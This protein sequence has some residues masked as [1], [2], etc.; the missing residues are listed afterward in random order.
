MD[1]AFVDEG[2][3]AD[4]FR[5]PICLLVVMEPMQLHH[6]VDSSCRAVLCR[7]CYLSTD[8]WFPVTGPV[9][10]LCRQQ[11]DLPSPEHRVNRVLE[12]LVH[13]LVPVVCQ[14]CAEKQQSASQTS[15]CL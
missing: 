5:C 13:H 15:L 9:C 10:P 3:M 7:K 1:S 12:G 6:T 4:L 8:P 14:Y 2:D 11:C